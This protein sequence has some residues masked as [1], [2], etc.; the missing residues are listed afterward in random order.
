MSRRSK[1]TAAAPA[2]TPLELPAELTIYTAG[3]LRP[4]W[5]A[6]LGPAGGDA[7]APAVAHGQAPGDV[8]GAGLQL[9]LALD[10][11]LAERG[12]KLQITAPSAALQAACA[13]AGLVDWLRQRSATQEAAA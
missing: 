7:E 10:R 1:N 13:A 9:L 11:S 8:D 12:R 3:E 4:Q 2:A 5:L 6:W